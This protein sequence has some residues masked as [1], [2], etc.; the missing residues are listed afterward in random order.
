MSGINDLARRLERFAAGEIVQRMAR[1][2]RDVLHAQAIR[3]FVEQ[4]DPYGAAWAPRKDRRGTWPLLQKTGAGILSLTATALATG[5]RLAI[6]GYFKF[7]QSGTS[8]MVQR[9]VFPDP[10]RGLGLWQ[11]PLLVEC[12]QAVREM[13]N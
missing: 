13:M 4:R 10:A 3:G 9:Q 6:R 11:E 12:G 5:A 1:R 2:A 8:R 7:H